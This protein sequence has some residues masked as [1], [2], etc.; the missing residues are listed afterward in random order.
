[1]VQEE[2]AS[3]I[4]FA[5]KDQSSNHHVLKKARLSTDMEVD[6]ATDPDTQ[7]DEGQ[8]VSTDIPLDDYGQQYQQPY[9]HYYDEAQWYM[10]DPSYYAIHPYQ[11]G[12]G[13][14][15]GRGYAF[16][17]R[18]LK[19][20]A[21]GV[22]SADS[23][24]NNN[25]TSTNEQPLLS[26]AEDL[27]LAAASVSPSPLVAATFGDQLGH[28]DNSFSYRG[29]GLRGRG[30]GRGRGRAEVTA[31]LASKS[32]SRAKSVVETAANEVPNEES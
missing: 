13:R 25:N 24:S 15:F 11:W 7:L 14:G 21:R 4:P 29:R 18:S 3:A 1:V 23:I 19:L 30:A 27:T 10:E 17:G 8:N 26:T 12:R 5:A 22:I 20:G 32:W 16:R 9:G 28:I 31:I 2:N 6:I